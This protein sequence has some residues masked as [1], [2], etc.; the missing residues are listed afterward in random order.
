MLVVD[1]NTDAAR[2]LE[3]V[4]KS[5][6]HEAR[7]EH[8]GERALKVAAAFKPDVVLLDLG[9]PGMDGFELARR[10]R[11]AQGPGLRVIAVTGWGQETDRQRSQEA[12]FD[13]HLVKPVDPQDLARIISER[14]GS[15]LH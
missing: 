11:K 12:G 1:D 3:L 2:A 10:L 4:L 7:V 14:N 13:L 15:T 8:D 9:L 6:G 5:L